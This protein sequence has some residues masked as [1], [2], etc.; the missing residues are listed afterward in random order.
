MGAWG[1]GILDNDTVRDVRDQYRDRIIAGDSDEG[2]TN[3]IFQEWGSIF[4]EDADGDV[5]LG[6]TYAKLETGRLDAA[7]K[8]K[9]ISFLEG[10][11]D[12]DLWDEKAKKRRAAVLQKFLAKLQAVDIKSQKP[13][14]LRAPFLA[15]CDWQE[16]EYLAYRLSSGEYLVL[17]VILLVNDVSMGTFPSVGIIGRTFS[18]IDS[19]D[20][21]D[22][23]PLAPCSLSPSGVERFHIYE[24]RHDRIPHDRVVRLNKKRNIT[25]DMKSGTHGG[26]FW[27]SLEKYIHQYRFPDT[28]GVVSLGDR[29]APDTFGGVI[30]VLRNTQFSVEARTQHP[31][32]GFQQ[33]SVGISD[34]KTPGAIYQTMLANM[35][36]GHWD[37]SLSLISELKQ[38]LPKE[39]MQFDLAIREAQANLQ[40]G[41]P[42]DEIVK[43]LEAWQKNENV[44]GLG[45]YEVR[46]SALYFI[47][48]DFQKGLALHRAAIDLGKHDSMK[49]LDLALAEAQYGDLAATEDSLSHVEINQVANFALPFLSWA[50]GIV[51]FGKGQHAVASMYFLNAIGPILARRTN[52]TIWSL[53]ALISGWSA[54]TLKAQGL[55]DEAKA[56]T[57]AVWPVLKVQ[58]SKKLL[59]SL[60]EGQLTGIM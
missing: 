15:E 39:N 42:L 60:S 13:K 20:D 11:G 58:G 26:T 12:L 27:V 57:Q 5:L 19:L 8:E 38:L 22:L 9:A 45:M 29:F 23:L 14:K 3:E 44:I 37:K 18:S 28:P 34:G 40:K 16:G 48:G 10:G 51:A 49:W 33:K 56:L 59:A 6:L 47:N 31:L 36:L 55:G 43:S 1:T 32:A 2:A 35:A 52:P 7:T 46:L 41:L 30:G 4:N 25:A 17:V 53:L 24:E 50:R 21:I 54:L